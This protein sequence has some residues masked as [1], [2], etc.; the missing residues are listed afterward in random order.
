MF[1]AFSYSCKR[2]IPRIC[3]NVFNNESKRALSSA[4]TMNR[5]SSKFLTT[6]V[7]GILACGGLVY[8]V[9]QNPIYADES[10]DDI[11]SRPVNNLKD[12][13]VIPYVSLCE[14]EG[15]E[16]DHA[17]PWYD[18]KNNFLYDTLAKPHLFENKKACWA[19]VTYGDQMCGHPG[20]A[21]GGSTAAM[22]DQYFGILFAFLAPRGFTANLNINYRKP[23]LANSTLIVKGHLTQKDR[24]KYF[25]EASVQDI[26]GNVYVEATSLYLEANVEKV[27]ETLKE[28]QH[29]NSNE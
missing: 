21:H 19:I 18:P 4:A 8:Y 27:V 24:R 15:F 29:E 2:F 11:Y 23:V 7:F 14:T 22:L 9:K 25:M 26:E 10:L 5:V 13:R 16:L 3:K 17:K 6:S 1:S 12:P 28:H 20:V